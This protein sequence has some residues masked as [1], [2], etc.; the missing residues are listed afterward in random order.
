MAG[1]RRG[2]HPLV[3]QLVDAGPHDQYEVES[4]RAAR[5]GRGVLARTEVS[6]VPDVAVFAGYLGDTFHHDGHDWR[7]MYTDAACSKWLLV[8]EDAIVT[9]KQMPDRSS[10]YGYRD[11]LWVRAETPVGYGKGRQSNL[12]RFLTGTF[13][14]AADFGGGP[15]PGAG[16]Y[17]EG[18]TG[19]FCEARTPSCCGPRSPR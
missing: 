15:A 10:A 6:D 13:T 5:A 4:A 14:R 7:V 1:A 11:V 2:P 9:A 18:T 12:S 17:G 3:K 19:V 8:L 16:T